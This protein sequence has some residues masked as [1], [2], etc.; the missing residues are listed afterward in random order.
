M[1]KI[2]YENN[3][4]RAYLLEKQ[5]IHWNITKTYQY[6]PGSEIMPFASALQTRSYAIF[7]P[8]LHETKQPSQLDELLLRKILA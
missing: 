6:H 3:I 7:H 8:R 2:V 4:D 5:C 1:I